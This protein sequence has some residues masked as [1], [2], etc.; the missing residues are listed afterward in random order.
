MKHERVRFANVDI[1]ALL[2]SVVKHLQEQGL[3]VTVD[4]NT[5]TFKAI[6]ATKQSLLRAA[7]GAVR[8]A[9]VDIAR[10]SDGIELTLRT[11]AWGRDIAIPAIEGFVLLGGVGAVGGAGA[12]VLMAHDFEQKFWRWLDNEVR[13]ASRGSSVP[14]DRFTPPM[15]PPEALSMGPGSGIPL[16]SSSKCPYCGRPLASGSKVCPYC[17][18]ATG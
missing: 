14:G 9:E 12:S 5:P 7:I 15:V 17:L 6:R 13:T 16:E 1:D 4:E 3:T 2:G 18:V 8:E 10:T 11:G